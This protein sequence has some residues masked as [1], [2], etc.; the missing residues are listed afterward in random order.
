MA[1][2]AIF[3]YDVMLFYVDIFFK[4]F[5]YRKLLIE[6]FQKMYRFNTIGN[7]VDEINAFELF[8]KCKTTADSAKN[9]I[10]WDVLCLLKPQRESYFGLFHHKQVIRH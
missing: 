2:S 8:K 7:T 3:D 4:G 10:F 5:L 6:Y 1:K 9:S